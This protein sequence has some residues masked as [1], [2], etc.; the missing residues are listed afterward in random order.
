M[1]HLFI[2]TLKKISQILHKIFFVHIKMLTISNFRKKQLYTKKMATAD[3][4]PRNMITLH[5]PCV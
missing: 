5:T 1:T 3:V 4:S 2:S